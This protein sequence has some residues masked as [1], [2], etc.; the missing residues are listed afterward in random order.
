MK[1]SILK[2]KS[3]KVKALIILTFTVSYLPA[4][5]LFHALS[6]PTNDSLA[7]KTAEWA[8]DN[9]LGFIVTNLE[10][11]QYKLNPVKVGGNT[12]VSKLTNISETNL[13][14]SLPTIVNP[15]LTLEGK[16]Q[17]VVSKDNIPVISVA[18]LRPDRL[19]TSYLTSVAYINLNYA[20]IEQHPGLLDPGNKINWGTLPKI[21]Q[22]NNS[23]YIAAFNSGFRLKDSMGGYYQNNHLLG[24]MTPNSASFIIYKDGRV[25][26]KKW[27]AS[28]VITNDISS[29][30]QN[31]A[32]LILNGKVN[33]DINKNLEN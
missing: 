15:P 5:S 27:Q 7:A 1:K 10:K 14:I 17:S 18:M 4:Y 20:K 8:R 23:G 26:I 2:T 3:F 11:I 21:S 29:I 19:H 16:Y 25:A 28:D 22:A 12:K 31:I 24:K 30:R 6:Q 9:H 13:P 32:P 33:I